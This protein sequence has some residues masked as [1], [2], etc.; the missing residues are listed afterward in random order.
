MSNTRL[1]DRLNEAIELEHA[2]AMHCFL[3]ETTVS[4]LWR[5]PLAPLF[6]NLGDEARQHARLF[7]QKVVALGDTPACEV[8]PVEEAATAEEMVAVLLALETRA[9]RT[10]AAALEAVDE[11]D[12]ALRNML[13]D[14]IDAEQR[15]IDEIS[16]VA[17]GDQKA[18]HPTVRA[19]S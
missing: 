12:V 8:G 15:H 17:G 4:G 14:H 10:Y 1:T 9:I 16:L 5:V 6:R 2:L 13:E 3:Y 11:S 18:A 7:G 19:A